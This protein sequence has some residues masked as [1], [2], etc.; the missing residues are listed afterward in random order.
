[1]QWGDPAPTTSASSTAQSPFLSFDAAP[2]PA[3][4]SPAKGQPETRKVLSESESDSKSTSSSDEAAGPQRAMSTKNGAGSAASAAK[5]KAIAKGAAPGLPAAA[6]S[7]QPFMP[8]GL[9]AA[10][11]TSKGLPP[12]FPGAA[13][14]VP[15]TVPH[16]VA[17]TPS[18][19]KPAASSVALHTEE[20]ATHITLRVRF[21]GQVKREKESDSEEEAKNSV[22]RAPGYRPIATLS[23]PRSPDRTP[24]PE[25]GDDDDE[26]TAQEEPVA[27]V[28]MD[29]TAVKQDPDIDP[30]RSKMLRFGVA[31]P[32]ALILNLESD[33]SDE[34][35]SPISSVS[36]SEDRKKKKKKKDKKA[37]KD[38]KKKDKK[39]K[40]SAKDKE[41]TADGEKD[42]EKKKK[43]KKKKDEEKKGEKDKDK[44]NGI[45]KEPKDEKPKAPKKT[46]E[47]LAKEAKKKAK[48]EELARLKHML[49]KK[50][51]KEEREAAWERQQALERG[52]NPNDPFVQNSL[53]KKEL[54]V[55]SG[56]ML[57]MDSSQ[58]DP[59]KKPDYDYSKFDP[60]ELNARRQIEVDESYS[61]IGRKRKY[62]TPGAVNAPGKDTVDYQ[63]RRC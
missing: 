43:D 53:G 54:A 6:K 56:K 32:E 13:K 49:E 35:E 37:K 46:P 36:D 50:K 22:V 21:S 52:E 39:E 63:G 1:M 27:D 3:K 26:Q 5:K 55:G 24:Y 20:S 8:P 14:A 29:G 7:A 41:A 4:A 28:L 12:G 9:P 47:Q 57:V 11:A 16:K 59:T 31:E 61:K 25:C 51:K 23:P 38:K 44:N 62:F 2:S 34:E 45:M 15:P 19:A 10:L 58:Y 33:L 42:K 18:A 17:A 48:L 30:D 60:S 40:E